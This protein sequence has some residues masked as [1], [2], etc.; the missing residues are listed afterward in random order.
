[1]K[2]LKIYL[3]NADEKKI[4]LHSACGKSDGEIADELDENG[5]WLAP[6][7]PG[8]KRNT[9]L[10]E[11]HSKNKKWITNTTAALYDKMDLHNMKEVI[12]VCLLSGFITEKD[13]QALGENAICLAAELLRALCAQGNKK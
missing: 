4:I 5:Q 7:R 8:E 3:P 2:A 1:M 12:A 11:L 13:F 6:L 9:L 10:Y